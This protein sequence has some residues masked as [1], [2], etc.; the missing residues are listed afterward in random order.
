MSTFYHNTTLYNYGGKY[1][2]GLKGRICPYLLKPVSDIQNVSYLFSYCKCLS[3]IYNYADNEDYMLPEGFFSYATKVNRLVD[4]LAYTIQPHNGVLLNCFKPLTNPL[5]VDECFYRC[6]WNGA[7]GNKTNITEVFR[8]NQL[9]SVIRAFAMSVNNEDG[10]PRGQYIT[11]S[12]IF[13]SSYNS[14][15][16]AA[17]SSFSQAFFG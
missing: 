15:R 10:Y 6:Y 14:A 11:F 16:Y 13:S 8:T 12:N 5:T 4:F 7:S 9:S 2:F 3:Y 1:A 17:N